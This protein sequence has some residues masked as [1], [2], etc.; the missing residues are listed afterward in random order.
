MLKKIFEHSLKKRTFS[1]G[2]IPEYIVASKE[3]IRVQLNGDKFFNKHIAVVGSTGSGKSCTVA[4]I[5]Q[6]GIEPTSNQI[7]RGVLNRSNIIIFDLHGE[8]YNAF[9]EKCRRL[10]VSDLK[11][12]FWLMNSEELEDF[13]LDTEG[14]DHN[15]KNILKKA[16]TWNK[17]KYNKSPTGSYN[18]KVT[19][20]S[21][22]YFS[23]KEVLQAI[24]NYNV[25]KEEGG[26]I[27]YLTSTGVSV[28]IGEDINEHLFEELTP[29][30][31]G[32]Q[33]SSFNGKFTGFITRLENKIS[34][35]D[36]YNFVLNQGND[37]NLPLQD[38]I[39]QI[40]GHEVS[41]SGK[42]YSK[43]N[44]TLIDLSGIPYEI[45]SMTVAILSRL[46]FN[47]AF[48]WKKANL[49]SDV[50]TPFLIVYEEAHNY[51]PKTGEAKYKTVRNAV[52]RIAKEGRKYGVSAMIVS[53]RP[54]EISETIFSQC[55]SFVVMR[56]TN[57]HDQQYIRKL[58]PDDIGSITD[59][60][61]SFDQRHALILGDAVSMPAIIEVDELDKNRLPKSNDVDFIQTWRKD[62]YEMTEFED[63][64]NNIMNK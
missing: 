31:G 8:Y 18:E 28:D 48:H 53:Q 62:W 4:K 43:T 5:L 3:K 55:N 41:I 47:F 42:D 59:N 51:I 38:I 40:I 24:K 17:K 25:A 21:P 1:F 15:Q 35:D 44:V 19:Y 27:K 63:I 20:D 6:E 29:I 7:S 57:P 14:S 36:R 32:R 46:V 34:G 50:E 12:P 49:N 26:K 13:F 33:V 39:K 61:S 54:S 11:L 10:T 22:V 2:S 30:T 58:L 64:V 52:E 60:L 56:L 9:K 37:Y 23:I 45:I 16:I